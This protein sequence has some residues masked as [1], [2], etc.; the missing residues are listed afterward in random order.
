MTRIAIL[1]NSHVASLSYAWSSIAPHYPSVELTFFA[2]RGLI[3][4]RLRTQSYC[5]EP[6][7]SV[8]RESIKFT[9]GG[10]V[11]IDPQKY[12]LF[13]IYGAGAQA[14]FR[15]ESHFYTTKAIEA[16]NRD[17]VDGTVAFCT[18]RKLRHI[19]SKPVYIGHA[20]LPAA[21]KNVDRSGTCDAYFNGIAELNR[22]VY[23]LHSAYLVA[24]PASTIVGGCYTDRKYTVGSRGL[25]VGAENDG[26]AH[27][28]NDEKHMNDKFG[29]KWL[30]GFFETI[31]GLHRVYTTD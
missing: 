7:D 23:E 13:I 29:D 9:S 8:L 15:D 20:P 6:S 26:R 4:D 19:T 21:P 14:N 17:L 28:E 18:L 25:S 30:S 10:E 16:A 27:K 12:D 22:T 2:A 31:M 1:G 5:L 24:Q 3:L 11:S